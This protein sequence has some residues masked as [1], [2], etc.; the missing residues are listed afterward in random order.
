MVRRNDAAALI[1]RFLCGAEG[2]FDTNESLAFTFAEK[3][4]SKNLPAGAFAV[5]YYYVRAHSSIAL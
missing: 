2:Y 4:A 5:A 1:V 3:A